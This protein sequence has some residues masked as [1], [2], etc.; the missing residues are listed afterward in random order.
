ME[1]DISALQQDEPQALHFSD[2][3]EEQLSLLRQ[4]LSLRLPL[5]RLAAL[6]TLYSKDDREPSDRALILLDRLLYPCMMRPHA[7]LLSALQTSDPAAA[8][9][10]S[11]LIEQYRG[12]D[13]ITPQPTPKGALLALIARQQNEG[14]LPPPP[15]YKS[16]LRLSLS[17]SHH[18][19]LSARYGVFTTERTPLEGSSFEITASLACHVQ[20][21]MQPVPGDLYSLILPPTNED[22]LSA[23]ALLLTAGDIEKKLCLLRYIDHSD[24]PDLLLSAPHGIEADLSLLAGG[25]Y[26]T[27]LPA[28]YVVC[29]DEIT[30]KTLMGRIRATGLSMIT[31]ARATS[32]THLMLTEN[33]A[34]L[35]SLPIARLRVLARPRTVDV[36][37]NS[38]SPAYSLP[39]AK[40]NALRSHIIL[41]RTLPLVSSLTA[42]NVRHAMQEDIGTMQTSGADP[43]NMR[44]AIG[45]TENDMTSQCALWSLVLGLW[46]AVSSHKLP[47]LP[48]VI[49][50]TAEGQPSAV[51]LALMAKMSNTTAPMEQ[52]KAE[53]E[54]LFSSASK[55]NM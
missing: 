18:A 33:R 3:N 54:P 43:A 30:T 25:D 48:P 17:P 50:P 19:P 55:E 2:M 45:I 21:D 24:Y 26:D 1:S 10:F 49:I 20:A 23:L 38:Q 28:G 51:T 22:S 46:Q 5:P 16:G 29:A 53:N 27:P 15:D 37:M 32:G 7:A 4:R 52:G 36:R 14:T 6:A 34:P 12:P 9:A 44:L 13:G 39:A 42:E 8:A 35:L 11:E 40:A 31:F 41:S 47:L